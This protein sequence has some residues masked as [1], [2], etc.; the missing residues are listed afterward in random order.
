MALAL[1]IEQFLNGWSCNGQTAG[2]V[3]VLPRGMWRWTTGVEEERFVVRWSARTRDV[4]RSQQRARIGGDWA[5][6]GLARRD[7]TSGRR[8]VRGGRETGQ[9]GIWAAAQAG[10]RVESRG[11]ELGWA[12]L[13]E[14]AGV[15]RCH[16]R[17]SG[18]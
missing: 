4:G 14:R 2:P 13:V 9:E 12:G 18:V 17:V 6:L 3:T 10:R 16:C 8:R 15:T 1:G 7:E 5:R 11:V